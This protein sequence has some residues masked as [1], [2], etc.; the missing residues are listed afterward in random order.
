[1]AQAGQW[2]KTFGTYNLHT[3]NWQDIFPTLSL[4]HSSCEQSEKRSLRIVSIFTS[5]SLCSPMVISTLEDA[6]Y[7]DVIWDVQDVFKLFENLCETVLYI[8]SG[9]QYVL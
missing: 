9:L 6:S 2:T 1:M 5:T 8:F 3:L 4:N 7:F